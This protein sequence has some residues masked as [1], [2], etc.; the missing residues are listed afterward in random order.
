MG[1]DKDR[2]ASALRLTLGR[3]TTREQ[4]ETAATQIAA[5]ARRLRAGRPGAEQPSDGARDLPD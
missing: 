4:A 5:A 3:W 1:Y 2:A